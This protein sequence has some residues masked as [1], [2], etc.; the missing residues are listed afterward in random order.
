MPLFR[1]DQNGWE[2]LIT[3]Q[4]KSAITKYLNV[5]VMFVIDKRNILPSDTGISL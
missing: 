1:R 4:Q 3:L 2:I 5:F